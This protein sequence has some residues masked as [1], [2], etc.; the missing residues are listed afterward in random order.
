MPDYRQRL[1]NIASV[2]TVAGTAL[3]CW[4]GVAGAL[5]LAVSLIG[6]GA[7]GVAQEVSIKVLV[8]DNPISD[9]DIDQRERFLAIT[10]KQEPSPALKKQAT[11]MLIDERL[12]LQEGRKLG[13]TP[14]A[15]DVT[16]ILEDMAQKNNLSVD[17][18]ATALGQTGVNIRRSRTASARKS[19]GRR[20]CGANSAATCRSAT[21]MSPRP[22]PTPARKAVEPRRRPPCSSGR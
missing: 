16:K 2:K 1:K 10:T 11:D 8:N 21:P 15:N 13:V 3:R 22:C 18:L 14:N 7:P 4:G 5:L 6:V 17:G 19:F 12:Q 9:Y 20:R